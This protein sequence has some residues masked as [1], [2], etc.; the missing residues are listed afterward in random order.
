MKKNFKN[1]EY[2]IYT[3]CNLYRLNTNKLF[4]INDKERFFVN[5]F[6]LFEFK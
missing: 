1:Q 2:K 4:T 5:K 3:S 6:R